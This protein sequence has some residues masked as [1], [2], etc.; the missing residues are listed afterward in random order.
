MQR[1]TKIFLII[2]S[3]I[4]F[5][6]STDAQK[7]NENIELIIPTFLGNW[8][9]NYYGNEAPTKLKTIWRTYLGKGKTVISKKIGEKEW[10]GTGWTGQ[11]LIV[12]ENNN[13]FLILGCYDHHLKKINA[14]NGKIVWQYL[15]DDV[16][17][18]TGTI[19]ENKNAVGDK[20]KYVV[21][22]GS[23]R[24]LKNDLYSKIVPSFRGISYLTGEEV[25]ADEQHPH[26]QL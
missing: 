8:Q 6:T 25:M 10:A 23:R 26:C 11:P 5:I 20:D 13:L 19:W 12:K 15:F 16:I 24:G 21:L 3:L 4:I 22:Q 9:R 7:N 18:G 14:H 2:V 17:K 1:L